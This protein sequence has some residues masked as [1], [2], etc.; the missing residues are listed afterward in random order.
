MRMLSV[1]GLTKYYG[2]RPVVDQIGFD[3]Q[4]GTVTAFLGPNAAGKSTTLRMVCGLTPPTAGGAWIAGRTYRQWANPCYVVGALLDASA[5]HPGRTGRGQLRM[6]AALTGLPARRVDEALAMVGLLEYADRRIGTYSLGLRQR[7]ALA[8]ALLAD[9]P[10]LLLDE[11]VNGLDPDGIRAIRKLLRT[12]AARGGTVFLSSHILAEVDQT[13]DR[14]LMINAG[15]IV[16]DG[17]VS[18][19]TQASGATVVR[20]E[21]RV[22]LGDLLHRIGIR[23]TSQPDGSVRVYAPVERVSAI[24]HEHGL[25]IIE[26]RAETRT[27][28]DV[29]FD[30]TQGDLR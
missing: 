27:L 5:T 6:A 17:P 21:E 25:R 26:L 1:R 18:V 20:T 11:P 24:V 8:Q 16:A 13:A 28:E 9:P 19:F 4:P 2:G 23:A 7:L 12:Y 10:L 29:F 22:L 14:L 3:L 30:L 15:R